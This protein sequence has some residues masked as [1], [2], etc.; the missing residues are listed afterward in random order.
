MTVHLL[1]YFF[2]DWFKNSFLPL[3]IEHCLFSLV[4][5]FFFSQKFIQF[6]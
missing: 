6:L 5:T 1:V 4:M 3:L 2:V